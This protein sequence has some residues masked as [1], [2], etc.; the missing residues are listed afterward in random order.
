MIVPIQ[1]QKEKLSYNRKM[2]SRKIAPFFIVSCLCIATTLNA[3]SPTQPAQNPSDEAPVEKSA[4][5]ETRK[6]TICLGYQPASLYIYKAATQVEWDVLQAIY[7]GPFDT[8]Q[9]ET[10]PVILQTVP[11]VQ[12]GGVQI[13][14][15]SMQAGERIID[16]TGKPS[17]LAAGVTYLPS[18]CTTSDCAITWNGSDAVLVDQT[19]MTFHFIDPLFW[20]D[21]TPLTAEDSVY[22]Y[23]LATDPSTPN[24]KTISDQVDSY[25]APDAHTIQVQLIPGYIPVNTEAYFFTPLPAH[26]W[27]QYTAA[28]LLDSDLTNRTPLGWGAYSIQE[29]NEDSITLE[30]NPYYFRSGEGLPYFD[31]LEFRFVSNLGDTNV[32]SLEF[33]YEPYE[34][35]EYNWSPDGKTVYSDQCDLIDATV[36]FSD[37]YDVFDYLTDYYITP[38]I[39]VHALPNSILDGLWLN[40]ERPLVTSLQPILSMC[41]DRTYVNSKTNY[42]VAFPTNSIYEQQPSSEEHGY[43]PQTASRLLDEM[44]WIDEDENPATPRISRGNPLV[45]DGIPLSM[46]MLVPHTPFYER[47]S[48]SVQASLQD[49]GIQLEVVFVNTWDFYAEDSPLSTLDFDLIPVAQTISEGFPC[50]SLNEPWIGSILPAINE[51]QAL[52]QLCSTIPAT[53]TGNSADAAKEAVSNAFPFIPLFYRTDVS[54]TRSDMCG[55]IP[56]VGSS[57]DLWNLEEF[58]YGVACAE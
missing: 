46:T 30:K 53:Q 23:Q 33:D 32:A 4:A 8:G 52:S 21:G 27:G 40:P 42:K 26:A 58:N 36:D 22:S 31:E 9:G 39:Q 7:D 11:T 44:G 48:A 49:C 28:E 15:V 16:A 50:S 35:L 45:A 37:Q 29:W 25:A 34:I 13:G 24:E 19:S 54:I 57:S 1:R 51:V 47:E 38:A 3:C 14:Q 10:V 17:T 20:S 6:I 43:D 55:F 2:S 5:T 12:N 18:G 56:T 41:I